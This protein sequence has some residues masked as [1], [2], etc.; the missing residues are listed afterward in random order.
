MDSEGNYETPQEEALTVQEQRAKYGEE[1]PRAKDTAHLF[2][3]SKPKKEPNAKELEFQTAEIVYPNAADAQNKKL[4]SFTSNTKDVSQKPNRLIWGDN[5]LVMQALLTQGYEG[6]IDVIYIDPPFNTGESFNFSNEVKIGSEVFEKEMPV[7]E[8]LA[9]T[10]TW[11][12][13]IDSFLDMIYPRLQL[14]R[15]LL[16]DKGSIFVHCDANASHYIKVVLDEIFGKDNFRNEIVARRINKNLTKQFESLTSL[17]SFGDTLYLYSKSPQT[18]FNAPKKEFYRKGYWHGFKQPADRPTM[19]YELLGVK[20]NSGQWMWAKDRADNAVRNYE[21]YLKSSRDNIPIDE[22]SLLNPN[23]EFIRLGES[24]MPEYY[25]P[26]QSFTICDTLWDDIIAYDYNNDFLTA[27]SE[28][29]VERLIK[30]G[31]NEVGIVADFFCGSGTTAAVAEKLGR[32]WITADL[33]KTAIQ[34]TRGRLVNQNANPFII[35]NLG[36]YQR[37]LIYAKEINLRQM[38]NIVLKL[39]GASPREDWQGFGTAKEDNKSLIF[40]CEPDRP[41][42]ARKAIELAK[43]ARTADGK[44]YKRLI[45]LAWDYDYDFDDVFNRMKKN[46]KSDMADVEFK[47][48]P[49]DVYRYLKSTKAGNSELT[50]KIT[51]YQKPYI[52]VSEPNIIRKSAEEAQVKLKIE[53]YTVMDIPVKDESKRPEIQKLLGKNFAYLID[54]WTVDWDYDGEVFRSKWQ[55]IRDRKSSEPVPIIAE[56][57]LAKGKKYNIAVR[58]VDVFGNDASVTKEIDLR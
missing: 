12:R 20:I 10:D 40:V 50:N 19:R 33:S 23:K 8:R 41:M 54:Y 25:L 2:W 11:D 53:K 51:F 17:T 28:K 16:S 5:L 45:I 55:A 32:R 44:G 24:G 3:A 34:V 29:F 57:T 14:M 38:Y 35:Q 48:I 42:T 43:F 31:S 37:Q 26:P 46:A 1:K 56:A 47:I 7:C 27:K 21:D 58:V 52:V 18:K 6:Q 30:M 22:Y 39:Y 13:G 36:N 9:Y 4:S 49:S 15:R